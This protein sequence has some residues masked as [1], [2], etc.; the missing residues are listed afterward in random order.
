MSLVSP[1]SNGSCMHETAKYL[2]TTHNATTLTQRT[3][4]HMQCVERSAARRGAQSSESESAYSGRRVARG[5]QCKSVKRDR[6]INGIPTIT[7]TSQESTSGGRG[8]PR[9]DS[10]ACCAAAGD[11][12]EQAAPGRGVIQYRPC[13]FRRGLTHE[14]EAGFDPS[15]PS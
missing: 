3:L 9:G 6:A 2:D 14:R 7:M 13:R 10:G 15:F 12:G 8:A 1:N 11:A 4:Q 5:E